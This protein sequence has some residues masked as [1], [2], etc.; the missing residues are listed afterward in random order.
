[1]AQLEAQVPA[2]EFIGG[3]MTGQAENQGMQ[4]QWSP[5]YD[6]IE[7]IARICHEANRALCVVNSDLSQPAWEDAPDWQKRS[8]IDGVRFH[9]ANPHSNGRDSHDRWMEV[10]LRDG[11]RYGPVKNAETKEH[12]CLLPHN[13]LP[14][15][16]QIK[17]DVFRSIVGGYV[18]G[19]RRAKNN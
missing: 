10:K 1:M 4:Q 17:D 5:N 16:E 11:W 13:A 3:G 12:P 2:K 14:P 8:A 19:M 6:D 7:K 15:H 18:G 9:I